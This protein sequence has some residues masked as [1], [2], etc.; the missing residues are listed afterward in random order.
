MHA[1]WHLFRE[2]EVDVLL[3]KISLSFRY[4]RYPRILIA[5][6]RKKSERAFLFSGYMKDCEAGRLSCV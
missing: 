6:L 4:T 3:F 2:V 1:A 5:P